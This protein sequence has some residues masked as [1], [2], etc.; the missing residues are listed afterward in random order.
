M[1]TLSDARQALR[2]VLSGKFQRDAAWNFASVAVLG[3][4]GFALQLVIGRHY[5]AAPLGV[6]NQVMAA[7]IVFGQAAVGGIN[8]STLRAISARRGDREH[9]S[10]IIFGASLPT[11]ALA[12]ACTALFWFAR[13]LFAAQLESPGVAFGMQAAAPGLFFFALNKVSMSIVNAAQRMRAF[14]IYTSLRYLLMV[15][16]L[17][18]VIET[19]M[20]SDRI[21][22]LFTF[23]EGLLFVP[24][25]VEVWLQTS[26]PFPPG[27]LVWTRE[28]LRYGIKSVASGMLL[29][30]NSRVDV[31]VIG[32]FMDDG[33]VGVYSIAAM[34]AEGLFQLLVVLQNNYNPLIAQ[35]VAE[36]RL[37]ELEAMVRRGKR[38]T[39]GLMALVGALAIAGFPLF[40][41]VLDKPEFHAAWLPFACLVAGMVAASGYMPFAQTLLMANRPGWHTVMMV[42]IV[43]FNLVG[44]LVLVPLLHLEGSATATALALV[45]SAGLL[46]A[47]VKKQVGVRL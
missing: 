35:H 36:N 10:A 14:A 28:H 9:V 37:S 2:Q 7:Y 25:A 39:Y 24:L 32:W 34:V 43:V 45:F 22:F 3:V 6:F 15:G 44:N 47:M 16:G 23:A 27:W 40:V 8:L 42:G 11:L 31:L 17:L 20:S 46:A 21:A 18:V 1:P 33:A 19:G 4:C 26:R 29:E 38:V 13:G 41:L 30:L 5:G 12:C